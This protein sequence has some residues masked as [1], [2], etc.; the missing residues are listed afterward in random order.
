MKLKRDK[1]LLNRNTHCEI[2]KLSIFFNQHF[3]KHIHQMEI[4]LRRSHVFFVNDPYSYFSAFS[5]L[6]HKTVYFEDNYRRLDWW[7]SY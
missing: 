5:V 7:K 1:S 6:D 2:F 3:Y 4:T